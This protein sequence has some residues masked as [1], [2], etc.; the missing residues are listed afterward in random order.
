MRGRIRKDCLLSISCSWHSKACWTWLPCKPFFL[1][2][3]FLVGFHQGSWFRASSDPQ[4]AKTYPSV[5]RLFTTWDNMEVAPL[6]SG[7]GHLVQELFA[8]QDFPTHC[9]YG[10]IDN[11]LSAISESCGHT[12]YW[13]QLFWGHSFLGCWQTTPSS[14]SSSSMIHG[15]EVW[16]ESCPALEEE[17]VKKCLVGHGYSLGLTQLNDKY[18]ISYFSAY[19]INFPRQG[20]R[21]V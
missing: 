12:E 7:W 9:H 16:F 5:R 20:G 3:S 8:G 11:Y 18:L 21:V 19:S 13:L 2:T 15:K 6:F 10:I 1:K 4:A 14:W 17:A